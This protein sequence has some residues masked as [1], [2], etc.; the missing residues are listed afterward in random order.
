MQST[1]CDKMDEK[2]D[3][4]RK[5]NGLRTSETGW[6][7]DMSRLDSLPISPVDHEESEINVVK[8][9]SVGDMRTYQDQEIQCNFDE[10]SK[11]TAQPPNDGSLPTR[12]RLAIL[13]VCTCMATFL[14]ALVR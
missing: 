7:V 2:P 13:V 9:S 3:Q 1:Q 4:D 12:S 8:T 10:K 11:K 6:S 5:H 14:Q